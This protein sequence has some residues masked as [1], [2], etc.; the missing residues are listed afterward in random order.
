MGTLRL[1]SIGSSAVNN[2]TPHSK[3]LINRAY[4][5]LS[6]TPK[7]ACLSGCM[8]STRAWATVPVRLSSANA[9]CA[10]LRRFAI[11]RAGTAAVGG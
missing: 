7:S 8:I 2:V 10:F 5:Q 9:N 11:S 1:G 3:E 4:N 6:S